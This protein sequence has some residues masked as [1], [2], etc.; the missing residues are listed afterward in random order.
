MSVR[1]S[2]HSLGRT[3]TSRR[4]VAIRSK[5]GWTPKT[6]QSVAYLRGARLLEPSAV[7]RSRWLHLR[8]P[9]PG[10]SDSRTFG[11]HSPAPRRGEIDQRSHCQPIHA[12]TRYGKLRYRLALSGVSSE[13]YRQISG[14]LPGRASL[15]GTTCRLGGGSTQHHRATS[16]P[17]N[18]QPLAISGNSLR[19]R[20]AQASE[21]GLTIC[22]I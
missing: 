15:I 11:R 3:L 22:K 5:E 7:T 19:R 4:A 1:R 12:G 14:T 10:S 6:K 8:G 20:A 21:T 16:V 17:A 13:S 9:Q 2:V 18:A